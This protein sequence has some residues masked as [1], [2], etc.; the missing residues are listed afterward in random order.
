M[1]NLL[2]QCRFAKFLSLSLSLGKSKEPKTVFFHLAP[3]FLERE[4]R[5]PLWPYGEACP[6]EAGQLFSRLRLLASCHCFLS[7]L[8]P[9]NPDDRN[10]FSRLRLS[11]TRGYSWHDGHEDCAPRLYTDPT[12]TA[13]ACTTMGFYVT[14]RGDARHRSRRI[15]EF[16]STPPRLGE[17]AR[18]LRDDF[19]WKNTARRGCCRS[20]HVNLRRGGEG[21]EGERKKL[22]RR[23][24]LPHTA[25]LLTRKKRL[26]TEAERSWRRRGRGRRRGGEG[27]AF[28]VAFNVR[29]ERIWIQEIY[30]P[31]CFIAIH[32]HSVASI[33]S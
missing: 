13:N 2:V 21:G 18:G 25:Y 32:F 29:G 27:C 30:Y 6:Y 17:P 31:G 10:Q 33:E 20:R 28:L 12:F 3:S 15:S 24:T 7:F 9:T 23:A 19:T 16:V 4:T 8:I 5:G 22:E 26:M 1:Q 14:N 11:V